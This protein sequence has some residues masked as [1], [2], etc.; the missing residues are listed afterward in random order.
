LKAAFAAHELLYDEDGRERGVEGAEE[1][2]M[3]PVE[4]L[5]KTRKQGRKKKK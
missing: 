1:P 5:A 4:G 3:E 2:V